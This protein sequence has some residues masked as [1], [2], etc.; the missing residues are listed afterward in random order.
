MKCI[1][2]IFT[3]GIATISFALIGCQTQVPT[4]SNQ[5]YITPNQSKEIVLTPADNQPTVTP[6]PA[7]F[8]SNQLEVTKTLLEPGQVGDNVT[9]RIAVK[10][11]DDLKNVHIFA[12]LPEDIEFISAKPAATHTENEIQ[13]TFPS[14]KSGR[15]QNVDVT[16]KP[17]KEGEHHI[18]ST[19]TV[20]NDFCFKFFAGQPKLNVV[21]N[22][23][24][25]IELGEI[26]TWTVDI[27]NN[28]SA[29]A[30]HIVVTAE[31]PDAFEPTD[32][33]QRTID[34]LAP[35]ETHT[36]EYSARAIRQGAFN[37]RILASFKNGI[38]TAVSESSAPIT[39]V[40]SNI[41]IGKSGPEEAYVF[42]PEHF[43]I[44]IENTGD[45]DLKNVRITDILPENSSISDPGK[46]RVNVNAIGWMIPNLPAGTSQLIT[47]EVTATQKGKSTSTVKVQT[48]NGLE[49]FDT[50]T[51][52]WLAVPGV[53]ISI[54]DNKDPIREKEAT[55]YRI[56]VRNQGDFEPVSGTVIVTFTDSIKPTAIAGDSEGVINGQ[57]VTFPRTTL[58]PGKDINLRITAE[59]A[60]IGSGRAVL[61]FSADFLNKPVVSEE[62]TNVY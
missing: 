13:Y 54:T 43:E 31:L 38:T 23:P 46:G 35:D 24:S 16:I 62:A 34:T 12:K 40:Q 56:Q 4:S 8:K 41:R 45:T 22:G 44:T 59:G 49:A 15:T 2:S 10:A 3:V 61:H 25:S 47:T 32:T 19:V 37:N 39:V 11:L 36:I 51:T 28:G 52:D 14:M 57:T 50:V 20:E 26:A 58:E 55:I 42:K 29:E 21:N 27:T 7:T 48:A 6:T 18:C 53:T 17:T 5:G 30:T 33:L 1:S 60:N 9:Y